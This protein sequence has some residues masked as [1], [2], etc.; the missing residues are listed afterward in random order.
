MF[1]GQEE[2]GVSVRLAPDRRQCHRYDLRKKRKPKVQQHRS[3]PDGGEFSHIDSNT[4]VHICSTLG[5]FCCTILE[6]KII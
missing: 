1:A 5:Y 4:K 2:G 6:G 3:K